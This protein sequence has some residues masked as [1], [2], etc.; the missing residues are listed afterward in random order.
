M[1]YSITSTMNETEFKK[2]DNIPNEYKEENKN[3]VCREDIEKSV[4]SKHKKPSCFGGH[5]NKNCDCD[6]DKECFEVTKRKMTIKSEKDY[7]NEIDIEAVSKDINVIEGVLNAN[8]KLDEAISKIQ[9]IY[10]TVS[11]EEAPSVYLGPSENLIQDIA[12][13]NTRIINL[14]K[15]LTFLASILGVNL[16]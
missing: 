4:T 16:L 3:K 14:N 15:S 5:F 9:M 11:G 10:I 12:A 8:D 6:W 2:Q 1:N 7:T 13:L